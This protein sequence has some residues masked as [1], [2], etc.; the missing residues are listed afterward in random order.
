MLPHGRHIPF[1]VT[2]SPSSSHTAFFPNLSRAC[3]VR[4]QPHADGE[5][6][7]VYEFNIINS[8]LSLS[9]EHILETRV[10]AM[11]FI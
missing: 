5:S 7:E 9:S 4:R 11:S 6:P 8:G 3:N 2:G 1:S 10:S